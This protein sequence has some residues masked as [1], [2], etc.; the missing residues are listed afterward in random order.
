MIYCKQCA[1]WHGNNVAAHTS[2]D[3]LIMKNVD[4]KLL[5]QQR[6]RLAGI[7]RDTL[8]AEQAEALDGVQNMLDYWSDEYAG[9][10]C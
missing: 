3:W 6:L 2:T 8:T 5:E 4:L 9:I 7:D 1:N 10:D